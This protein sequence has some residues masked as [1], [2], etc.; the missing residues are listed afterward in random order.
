MHETLP[1]KGLALHTPRFQPEAKAFAHDLAQYDCSSLQEILK[2]NRQIAQQNKL[3]Y[4]RFFDR[5][6]LPLPAIL[7]YHGQ[8]YKHLKAE[9]LSE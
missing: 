3:R 7:A 1:T 5:D 2:C 8:A 6:N 4:L 9:Q